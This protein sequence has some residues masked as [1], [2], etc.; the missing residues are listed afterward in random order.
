MGKRSRKMNH[1]H[2]YIV[3]TH[4]FGRCKCGETKQFP[5][6][7]KLKVNTNMITPPKYDP[8]SWLHAEVHIE[9]RI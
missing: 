1:K 7:Q 3:D 5:V 4:N 8:D 9:E 6:E 2:F